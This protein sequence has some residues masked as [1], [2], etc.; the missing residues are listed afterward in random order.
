[1]KIFVVHVFHSSFVNYIS[2]TPNILFPKNCLKG[3]FQN[4]TFTYFTGN[5]TFSFT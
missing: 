1:M 4:Y 5:F 3:H 2:I